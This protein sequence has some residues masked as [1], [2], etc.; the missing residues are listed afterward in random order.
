MGTNLHTTGITVLFVETALETPNFFPSVS[1]G[2][3]L[4]HAFCKA[5]IAQWQNQIKALAEE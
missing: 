4:P 3:T 5:T 1:Q 2:G